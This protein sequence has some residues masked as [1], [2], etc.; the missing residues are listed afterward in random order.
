MRLRSCENAGTIV[1]ITCCCRQIPPENW[2]ACPGLP[3]RQRRRSKRLPFLL[4]CSWLMPA[5]RSVGVKDFAHFAARL[6]QHQFDTAEK[7][8]GLT[9]GDATQH[10]EER[11]GRIER[12]FDGE[13]AICCVTRTVAANC[14]R[15]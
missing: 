11:F 5:R 8:A 13:D 10:A 7:S 14:Y 1:R 15:R 6:S 4:P 3:R 9:L 12:T 2:R